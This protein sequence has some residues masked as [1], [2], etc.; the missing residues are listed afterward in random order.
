MK[1]KISMVLGELEEKLNHASEYR[2]AEGILR[3]L[4]ADCGD[5]KSREEIRQVRKILRRQRR[6]VKSMFYRGCFAVWAV[7]AVAVTIWALRFFTL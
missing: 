4:S 7:A 2:Q 3:D 1:K 6:R 5:Q